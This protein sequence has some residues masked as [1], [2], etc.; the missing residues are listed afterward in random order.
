MQTIGFEVFESVVFLLR[1]GFLVLGAVVFWTLG[2][3]LI[4]FSHRFPL[5]FQF[6]H[7]G[8]SEQRATSECGFEIGG[9]LVN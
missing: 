2:L 7:R 1:V 6:G 5:S 9:E 4:G 8:S 3:G